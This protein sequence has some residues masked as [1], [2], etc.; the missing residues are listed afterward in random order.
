M[1][2]YCVK[3]NTSGIYIEEF[4]QEVGIS[5]GYVGDLIGEI[6]LYQHYFKCT[7]TGMPI[8]DVTKHWKNKEKYIIKNKEKITIYIYMVEY[9]EETE[10]MPFDIAQMAAMNIDKTW[11]NISN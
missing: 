9:C 5:L 6:K 1:S 11:L 3:I 4:N 10:G 8:K 2:N 7:F